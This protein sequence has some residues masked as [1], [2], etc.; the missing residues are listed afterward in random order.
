MTEKPDMK[1]LRR[2]DSG[3]Q[4][5]FAAIIHDAQKKYAESSDQDL[6]DYM[7]PPMT[8]VEDMLAVIARQNKQFEAFRAKRQRIFSA[9][10][11]ALMP[12]EV[13][14]ES[15]AGA[16]SEVFAP[17]QNIFAAVMYLVNAAKDVS[18]CYDSIIELFEK[19]Q[20]FTSRLR[21]YVSQ[22]LSPELRDKL[23]TILVTVFEI[24][25]LAAAEV[26]RGRLKAYFKRLFG[27]E[28]PVPEA[29]K[30]LA[31]LT[32]AEGRLV[33]A[34]TMAG[35]KQSLSN[36]ERLLEMMTRVDVNVQTLRTETREQALNSNR[37]KLRDILQPSVFPQDTYEAL[38]RTRTPGTCEWILQDPAF[39]AWLS[40]Q[41]RF[42][43]CCGNPGTGKSH[44]TARLVRWGLRM[45]E[46]QETSH[47][48]GYFFFRQTDPETR[49]MIQAL[50]DIAYQVS[51]VDVFY[52]KQLLRILSSSDDIKTVSSAFRR[53]LV[54]PCI[55]DRWQRNIYILLDGVDE[56]DQV[57]LRE[58]ISLLD[59]LNKQ[60]P[61]GTRVQVALFGRNAMSETVLPPLQNDS[62]NGQQLR[63]L[64][65]TA[66]RNGQDVISYITAGVNEARILRGTPISFREEIVSVM[67]KQVDGSG[68]FIL[69]KF[70]LAELGRERHARGIL[71]KLQ[72]YPQEINGMLRQ[73]VLRFSET[74]TQ[75]EADDLNEV[76]RWVACAE[77]T[78]TLEQVEVILAL[79]FGDPPLRLEE[80]LRTQLAAFFT[81]EREDGMSTAELVEQHQ[82][83]M[84]AIGTSDTPLRRS[85]NS[86]GPDAIE[87]RSNKHTTSVS[88]FHASISDFF[89]DDCSTDLR[90]SSDHPSIGFEFAAAKLHVL[91]TC[92]RIFTEPNYP[93]FG[94]QGLSLQKYAAWYWQEH[95]EHLDRDSLSPED[96][97]Q[98][99]KLLH[100]MLTERPV[101]LAWTN[102]FEEALDIW[103]DENIE[104]VRTWLSDPDVISGLAPDAVAWAVEAVKTPSGP[105]I[106]MGSVFADA[107]LKEDF[108]MYMPTLFCFGVVQ[109]LALMS[110]GHKW[111]DSD[112]HWEDMSVESRVQIAAKWASLPKGAHWYRR[113]GSTL[114]NL[115]N[116]GKALLNFSR[117]MELDRNIQ[118]TAGRMGICYYRAGDYHKALRFHLMAI[119]VDERTIKDKNATPDMVAGAR[120]RL[121]KA[122]KEA[123]NCYRQMGRVES[124][125]TY[126]REAIKQAYD[127]RPFEPEAALMRVL[128]ENNR[129]P[130]IMKL[131]K[132]LDERYTE[133]GHSR[134]VWFML[135]QIGYDSTRDWIPEAAARTNNT[136]TIARRYQAAIALA[137]DAQNSRSEF[138]LR[139]ALGQVY[140][141]AGDYDRAIAIQEEICQEW[142]P[143]GS[144]AV[145]VEYANS[146]KNLACLY[147]LKALQN[148]G[149]LR[150][151]AV[152]PWIV[153]LE[154][155]QAQQ[156]KHQNRNVPLHMAGFDVNEASI[157]L[158]LFY[159]FRDRPDE[160]RELAA[161]LVA[162]HLDILEDD[163]PQNDEIGIR[164]LQRTLIA[165][166]DLGNAR[167]LWQSTRTPV[168]PATASSNLMTERRVSSPRL[169][170]S[171]KRGRASELSL[172][173]VFSPTGNFTPGL[174]CDYCLRRFDS[175]EEY[176]V[177]VY[178]I[179]TLFCLPCLENVI[180]QRSFSPG[181]TSACG[182]NHSFMNVPPLLKELQPGE[183]MVDGQLQR[184]SDWKKAL[185]QT[186]RSARARRSEGSPRGLGIL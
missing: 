92:L 116:Y 32:E 182:P 141:A 107:W 160:A 181:H 104:V 13:V 99:G 143:R 113:I 4:R 55:P 153:K 109:C 60:S 49:S 161:S 89:R 121:Y 82:Q 155:L 132:E 101:I 42:L 136:A 134:L 108:G 74:I 21:F 33:G 91:L 57:Q 164:N 185:R 142:K 126:C 87:F 170:V 163:E 86:Q 85:P 34:E 3:M 53:L 66:D 25:V 138:Y 30:R 73:S 102:L 10:S 28:S 45:M 172:G 137:Q 128:A 146:F 114:L 8:S 157:F 23:V 139:N 97:A 68:Q 18:A 100:I 118:E 35:V 124:A 186:F 174:S 7:N 50:R 76:L 105:L 158:V 62:T 83:E 1:D 11:A 59:G 178:C 40:G 2:T 152:D 180:K 106:P 168:N 70:M 96:K 22:H 16:A 117:A 24:F 149:T 177:C 184:F 47:M 72:S 144:I 61:G 111:S 122:L 6:S 133:E 159:R 52:G 140:R 79:K 75:A 123:S 17:S 27:H 5:Q 150:T 162:D 148:D 84:Q 54:E 125:L 165:A 31:V 95:L 173:K 12:I 156:S 36:Q 56:A 147:Y 80:S 67:T 78:L 167:A 44:L 41:C 20:D 65:V 51:E 119:T 135:D 90:L 154:E 37:D 129:I 38:D 127:A 69:A 131:L 15:L 19:M 64:H 48:L 9:M 43:F 183:I 112:T 88:F 77:M 171:P 179:D 58:F 46:E 26:R 130:E 81:L 14:G 166:G 169:G 93:A 29:L 103:T 63:I 39:D 151:V 176:V 98:I 175:K 110:R 120:W 94:A 71:E 115:G 145:R